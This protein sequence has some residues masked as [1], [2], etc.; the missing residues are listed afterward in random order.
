MSITE[1][2]TKPTMAIER[3]MAP[4]IGSTG[5]VRF[6]LSH[7]VVM[8]SSPTIP[9]TAVPNPITVNAP[10]WRRATAGPP[11]GPMAYC[12]ATSTVTAAQMHA[13]EN[14]TARSAPSVRAAGVVAAGSVASS[15]TTEIAAS[16]SAV[17][18]TMRSTVLPQPPAPRNATRP[19]RPIAM[20]ATATQRA[21]SNWLPSA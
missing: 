17:H 16:G 9:V 8:S 2:D 15:Q 10:A 6:P 11:E 5:R 12:A 19:M 13:A 20:L 14:A 7:R 18:R 3:A 4:R 1:T 21:P